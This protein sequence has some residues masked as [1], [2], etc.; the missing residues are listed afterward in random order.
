MMKKSVMWLLM[1]M[2]SWTVNAQELTTQQPVIDIGQVLYRQPV[3]VNFQLQNN[4]RETVYIDK[5]KTSC[6]CTTVDMPKTAVKKGDKLMLAATY[7]A[8][9]MG[10]FE[11]LV[12]VYV[13]GKSEPVMLRM[14]GV[15]VSGQ[16]D[17]N[18]DYVCTIGLLKTDKDYIEFEDV[19]RG[20]RPLQELR[21]M[22]TTS[23]TIEPVMMHL[24]DYLSASVMPKKIA[25]GRSGVVRITL[26]TQ[27]MPDFGLTQTSIYLGT[28]PGDKVSEEKE[29]P[30]SI[31]LLPEYQQLSE[32]ERLKAPIMQLYPQT[33]DLGAF[34]GKSKKKG[35][36]L[37]KNVGKST[38]DIR[39]M[40]LFTPGMKVSLNKTKIPAGGTAKMT[41]TVSQ[42]D[43]KKAR[44]K[45]RVLMITNDPEYQ[46]AIIRVDVKD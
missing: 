2:A 9:Q 36:V 23:E 21:V 3:T 33:L 26:N 10:H 15:V 22:N 30:V 43:L 4:G 17:F 19:N 12:G 6:G 24:P 8:K 29:I 34:A 39:S 37:I 20:D 1:A 16:D 46:K 40:Q 45:P 31:V 13:R 7:D 14:R 28:F 27:K 35:T 5:V 42:D 44:S 11:K 38:L 32:A 18:G 41:I 25:P